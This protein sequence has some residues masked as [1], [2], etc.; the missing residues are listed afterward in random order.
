MRFGTVIMFFLAGLLGLGAALS[1]RSV[2]NG[3][4][5]QG[6]ITAETLV[7]A[8]T[9]L[10]YGMELDAS[11]LSE[12]TWPSNAIP[13][14][15]F[16]TKVELLKG[17]KR[18]VLSAIEANEP[19]LEQKITGP[20]QRASLSALID[21]DMTAVTVRVD[22][23]NGVGGFVLPGDYVD[24]FLT[25]TEREEKYTD[26]LLKNVRV[27]GI[28]Q[29]ADDRTDKPQV[30]KAVTL[31]LSTEAAQK[32]VL[33]SRV[34]SISL[35]LRGVGTAAD[36]QSRRVSVSDLSQTSIVGLKDEAEEE[37]PEQKKDAFS[38]IGVTR[39]LKRTEY[40]VVRTFRKHLAA[41]I[42]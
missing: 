29:L 13:Q 19:I 24:V 11:N 16:R 33:A 15:A 28:D 8:A 1:V 3:Q 6:A 34:G 25:R 37:G 5:D 7:V 23:V 38:I 14:G 35:S 20:G 31:E 4:S 26:V 27:L 30:A 10:R 32:V 2:L 12:I 39:S 9:P 21:K 22:D 36:S 17:E 18:L 40:P 41:P 42:E